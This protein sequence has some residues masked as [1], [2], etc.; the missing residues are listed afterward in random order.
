MNDQYIQWISGPTRGKFE[1][2]HE[3]RHDG[4]TSQ[5][6][7]ILSNGSSL[8]LTGVGKNFII[9]PDPSS[10]LNATEL[11]MMYPV[12]SLKQNRKA[13][14]KKEHENILGFNPDETAPPPVVEREAPKP[15]KQTQSFSS[16]LLSRAKKS[17]TEII[18]PFSVQMPSSAFFSMITETFDDDTVNEI[19]DLIVESISREEIKNAIKTSVTNFYG[20][21]Q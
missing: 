7:V 6:L 18:V 4:Q 11:D 8:P 21:N 20:G 2:I 13:K 15:K 3:I 9:L 12:E 16:D 10:A 14:P 17:D 5:D 1:A 19:I